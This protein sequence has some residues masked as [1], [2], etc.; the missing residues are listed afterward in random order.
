MKDGTEEKPDT[1]LEIRRIRT[2]EAD[3]YKKLRLASLQEAPYAFSST[4]ASA[5]QRTDESWREQVDESAQSSDRALFV[6]ISGEAAV[7]LTALVRLPGLRGTGELHQV[8]VA[9]GYRGKGLAR[10]LLDAVF[11]WARANDLHMILAQITQGNV[12]ALAFYRKYGFAPS[13]LIQPDTP[14][15]E[16]LACDAR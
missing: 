13:G 15:D 12:R 8:W 4:Y 9:P 7:G 2:G 10:N 1:M 11:A 3:L 14:G 6:A 16:V 5:L